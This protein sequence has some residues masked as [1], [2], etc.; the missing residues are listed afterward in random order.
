MIGDAACGD[1]MGLLFIMDIGLMAGLPIMCGAPPFIIPIMCGDP[2]GLLSG[3]PT[4]PMLFIGLDMGGP[5][6]I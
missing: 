2:R 4:I 1:V 5:I 6:L 3:L